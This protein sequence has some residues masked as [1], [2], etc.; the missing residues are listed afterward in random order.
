M[1]IPIVNAVGKK[2]QISSKLLNVNPHHRLVF[3]VVEGT[4]TR[5]P[6][7]NY[8]MLQIAAGESVTYCPAKPNLVLF[9]FDLDDIPS[10]A[11]IVRHNVPGDPAFE[12]YRSSGGEAR[13]DVT[14]S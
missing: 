1:A 8:P 14:F 2:V 13:V 5:V 11:R 10:S 3:Q 4:D 7:K 12:V 6:P 9:F